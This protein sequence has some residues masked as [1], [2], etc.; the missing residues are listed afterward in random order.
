VAAEVLYLLVA[1][2]R[3]GRARVLACAA[4]T[5][6]S[7]LPWYRHLGPS[8]AGWRITQDWLL[9]TPGGFSRA[10]AARDQV[11]AYFTGGEATLWGEQLAAS[12]AALTLFALLGL[13]LVW[14]LR[15]RAFG[16][17]RLFLWLWLGAAWAG[18]LV[19]DGLR[20]THT[21][22]YHRYAVA[23]LPAALLLAASA[24]PLLGPRL[25]TAVLTLVCLAWL[26]HLSHV[27]RRTSRSWGP[28][29]EVADTLEATTGARDLILVHSIPS[30]V[31]GVARY[32]DGEGE[33]AAWVEQ[34]GQRSVPGPVPSMML[35]KDQVALVRIHEVG[36]PCPVEDWLRAHAVLAGERWK[37][38]AHTLYFG[39]REVARF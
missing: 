5:L 29:R 13:V 30:G 14:R 39:V 32:Y 26:P 38:S 33:L 19:F 31:L 23:G 3:A 15:A 4:A 34:L 10:A 17:R 8:L 9:M 16:G 11:L 12:R 6:L 37:E 36:A 2:G 24:A 28:A 7:I 21:V 18:P 20:G 25:R 27:V 1:P 22:A 35:G